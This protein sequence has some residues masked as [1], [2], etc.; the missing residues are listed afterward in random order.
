V[1]FP[2][3]GRAKASQSKAEASLVSS[4]EGRP[5][6]RDDKTHLG[7]ALDV[8]VGMAAEQMEKP[9]SGDMGIQY[10][11]V[12]EKE[13]RI[14]GQD[15]RLGATGVKC[16]LHSRLAGHDDQAPSVSWP[17]TACHT[18]LAFQG[19]HDLPDRDQDF[20]RWAEEQH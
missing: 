8:W 10:G 1:T 11:A 19:I 3:Q 12:R 5:W 2:A 17:R 15:A 20:Q 9:G 18:T 13:G 6:E 4:V 14:H 7:L 16:V